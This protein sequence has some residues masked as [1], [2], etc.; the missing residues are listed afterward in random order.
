[1][2]GG[3]A[4]VKRGIPGVNYHRPMEKA[5]VARADT[6]IR[7]VSYAKAELASHI[8]R[9]LLLG[10]SFIKS[11]SPLQIDFVPM[12]PEGSVPNAAKTK[13]HQVSLRRSCSL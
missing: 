6:L 13:R 7:A 5:L 2:S 12:A 10:G 9:I 8:A 1:M 4:H 11:L 3:G